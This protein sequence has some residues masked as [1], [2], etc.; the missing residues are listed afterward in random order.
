[1]DFHLN[2]VFLGDTSPSLPSYHPQVL[3]QSEASSIG[4]RINAHN[5]VAISAEV[6]LF[7]EDR[8]RLGWGV[9]VGWG[10]GLWVEGVEW[11]G[12]FSQWMFK[13]EVSIA[14][15]HHYHW[16]GYGTQKTKF[17]VLIL[18]FFISFHIAKPWLSHC[19]LD[20]SIIF[21]IKHSSVLLWRGKD[22]ATYLEF[23]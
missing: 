23:K 19:D 20:C 9:W 18:S 10:L 12:R 17:I 15:P 16:K 3:F 6:R 22:E 14:F 21:S 11:P 1:M 8:G 7:A 2:E 5:P 4:S 13:A